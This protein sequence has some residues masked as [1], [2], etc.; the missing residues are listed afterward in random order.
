MK[1]Q[2]PQNHQFWHDAKNARIYSELLRKGV[3]FTASSLGRG[4]I[5]AESWMD[6]LSFMEREKKK[7]RKKRENISRKKLIRK[8]EERKKSKK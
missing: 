2:R 6:Q 3:C 8:K 5:R 1:S 4:K 7:E